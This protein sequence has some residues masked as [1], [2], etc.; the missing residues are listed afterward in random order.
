MADYGSVAG[1]QAF[2]RHMTFDSTNN[3]TTDDITNFLVQQSAKV[4]GWLAMAGYAIPVELPTAKAALD[5]FVNM[6]AAGL[7]E[8]T[9]RSA[10]YT[11]DQ[12]DTRERTFL[13]EFNDVQ[14]F[15]TSGALAAMGVS[16]VLVGGLA[17]QQPAIGV[18][19]AGTTSD[20]TRSGFPPEWRL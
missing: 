5:N 17:A 7:A 1:V 9:Q 14:A 16:Q 4:N 2:V 6:G 19:T 3:P 11:V 20:T 10:G 13:D 8:L 12:D 18:I 15:I